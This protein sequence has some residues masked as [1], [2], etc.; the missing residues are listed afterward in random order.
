MS[1]QKT[2]LKNERTQKNTLCWKKEANDTTKKNTSNDDGASHDTEYGLN[3][4]N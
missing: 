1:K 3:A 2:K 4:C